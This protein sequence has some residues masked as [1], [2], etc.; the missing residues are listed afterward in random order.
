V[1][2]PSEDGGSMDLWNAGI[3]PQ[4]Y[5]VSQ[6][7][8]GGSMDLRNV[9]ILPQHYTAQQAWRPRLGFAIYVR[10]LYVLTLQKSWPLLSEKKSSCRT[11]ESKE[12]PCTSLSWHDQTEEKRLEFLELCFEFRCLLTFALLFS[13]CTTVEFPMQRVHSSKILQ[14][15]FLMSFHCSQKIENW[16]WDCMLT[17][18]SDDSILI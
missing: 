2:Q 3:L 15:R 8:D 11:S 1:S 18:C 6:P 10:I 17:G 9:G 5:T 13:R 4:Y 12:C 14:H 7:A 16:K